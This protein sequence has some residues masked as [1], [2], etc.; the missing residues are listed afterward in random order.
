MLTKVQLFRIYLSK[1][2]N[3]LIEKTYCIETLLMD[4]VF[5]HIWKNSKDFSTEYL[6][7]LMLNKLHH[8]FYRAEIRGIITRR[9]KGEDC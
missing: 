6:E 9:K 3:Q 7:D 8:G 1:K 4:D 2:Y 5:N